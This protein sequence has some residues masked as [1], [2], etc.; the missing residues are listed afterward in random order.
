MNMMK[1]RLILENI[2]SFPE[3]VRKTTDKFRISGP[4]N[5]EGKETLTLTFL[6]GTN[7]NK[8]IALYYEKDGED[9]KGKTI[10]EMFLDSITIL[11]DTDIVYY[12]DNG[13][14]MMKVAGSSPEPEPDIDPPPTTTV[15][16]SPFKDKDE[17]NKFRGWV[18]DNYPQIANDIPGLPS[19]YSDKTLSRKGKCNNEYI[20]KASEHK[21]TGKRTLLDIFKSRTEGDSG[22]SYGFFKD[23]SDS[24]SVEGGKILY[25]PTSKQY[26]YKK[27][28]DGITYHLYMDKTYKASKNGQFYERGNW[29]PTETTIE[30]QTLTPSPEF[31]KKRE[32]DAELQSQRQKK[33]KEDKERQELERQRKQQEDDDRTAADTKKTNNQKTIIDKYLNSGFEYEEVDCNPIDPEK[34]STIINLKKTDP[35]YFD[36]DKCLG[37][38]MD[39][40]VNPNDWNT[41]LSNNKDEISKQIGG[42]KKSFCRKVINNYAFASEKQFKVENQSWLTTVKELIKSCNQRHKFNFGTEENLK[43]I[44]YSRRRSYGDYS[45]NEQNKLKSLVKKSLIEVKENKKELTIES[46]IVKNRYDLLF[47]SSKN[48]NDFELS[49][50][51]LLN[52]MVKL[53]QSGM[54]QKVLLE[55]ETRFV[56]MLSG[57]LGE[58]SK[59]VINNF[60]QYVGTYLLNSLGVKDTSEISRIFI[61]KVKNLQSINNLPK[62]LTDCNYVTDM[63]TTTFV[64]VLSNR[65]SVSSG[66]DSELGR[67]LKNYLSNNSVNQDMVNSIKGQ[68]TNVVCEKMNDLVEKLNVK[69]NEIKQKAL[70]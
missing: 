57:L 67:A 11:Q 69:A 19:S 44:M 23:L 46:S 47:E 55:Q 52:E 50:I 68:I 6:K 5:I 1:K 49:I 32:Q 21:P 58:K 43:K 12:C 65:V 31:T 59:D 13:N 30:E 64:D 53:R 27:D 4:F 3:C 60:Y 25:S 39:Y 36:S 20:K 8:R 62:L 41:F 56:E 61:D 33:E 9:F 7:T 26:V 38:K 2:N 42:P 37:I 48:M 24:G 15:D 66:D 70:S 40:K 35:Q 34:W 63:L 16:C 54:S 14:F 17:A 10:D 28:I 18:N 29:E 51:S 45:L 22:I